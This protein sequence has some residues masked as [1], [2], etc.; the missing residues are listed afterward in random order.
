MRILL[1][2]DDLD[3]LH[4]A[5]LYLRDVARALRRRGHKPVVYG[6]RAGELATTLRD[7]DIPVVQSLRSLREIPDVVFGYNDVETMIAALRFPEVPVLS[8]S[9]GDATASAPNVVF[10]VTSSDSNRERLMA[11]QGVAPEKI[12]TRLLH[13][14]TERVEAREQAPG[15]IRRALVLGEHVR[16]LETIQVACLRLEIELDIL[17]PDEPCAER[18][19][20][21]YDLVFGL[22]HGALEAAAAGCALI[23]TDGIHLAAPLTVK[24]FDQLHRNAFG[25][26]TL[27]IPATKQ[28]LLGRMRELNLE[29][30][31]Q[32]AERIRTVAPL[33][34]ALEQLEADAE[35]ALRSMS[36]KPNLEET[37]AAAARYVE[38]F[39]SA[40]KLVGERS[41]AMEELAQVRSELEA[42]RA[43][44]RRTQD[45]FE[46]HANE[47]QSLLT[48]RTKELGRLR[49]QLRR[50][51]SRE[52]SIRHEADGLR[53]ELHTARGQ[54][55][56]TQE[57][58]RSTLQEVEALVG[59]KSWQVMEP[60]RQ[61]RRLFNRKHVPTGKVIDASAEPRDHTRE[62]SYEEWI[63]DNDTIT[64]TD[65]LL[66]RSH[67]AEFPVKPKL[68]IVMPVYDVDERFLRLALDSVLDQL[69]E[70]WELCIA[71]DASPAPH[72]RRVLREYEDRDPRVRVVY[73]RENGH[74]SAAS[75]SA[76][77]I[78]NGD[79]MV[80]MDHDD[81]LP[82]HALYMVAATLDEQPQLDLIFSDEDKIDEN[83]R[84]FAPYFKCEF[85]LDL[86]RSHNMV[87]HLGV[88]RMSIVKSIGGFRLGYEGSQDYDLALR[89]LDQTSLDRVKHIPFILYHW[90]AIQGS[91]AL[92]PGE[93]SYAHDAARRA[94]TD[95]LRRRGIDATSI[96]TP[97]NPSLH[98][99]RYHLTTEPRVSIVI[100]TKDRADLLSL[101]VDSIRART[102]YKNFEIVVA[103]NGSEEDDTHRLFCEIQKFDSIRVL[104]WNH[105]FNYSILNNWAVEQT[106]A[107]VI[108]FLNNDIEVETET[109]LTEMVAHAVQPDIGCVGARLYYPDGRLQHAGITLGVGGIA[110]HAYRFQ[111]TD[112]PGYF[113]RARVQQSVSAVT[114]ACL[115]IRRSVF[116]E[117]E[118]FDEQFRVAYGDVDLCLRASAAGY[119]TVYTPYAELTHHE[120]ATRGSD[121]VG[122]A[123]ERLQREADMMRARW[124]A[125]LDNDPAYSPNLTLKAD[126]FSMARET[127]VVKP[128]RPV[129]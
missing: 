5:G 87:S 90:R 101:C 18:Q 78:A 50:F 115:A 107:T 52:E 56:R 91:V 98:R 48:E 39:S 1:A 111:P 121:A 129:D 120:S 51:E 95:S 47:A 124:A 102:S 63:R 69:Y 42:D 80:L 19:L 68:S 53:N 23:I 73:R 4:D 77:E 6:T 58:H 3:T 89:F 122:S 75:N 62:Y 81:E 71:D 92:S 31:E 28:R 126:D 15:E 94:I 74:I 11:E 32:V 44:L 41:S 72:I 85:N 123:A 49:S 55:L 119:R 22:G 84:R 104:R 38:A 16:E 45:E 97:R 70:N 96:A 21:G 128:W 117:V 112:Y 83:G 76:I 27:E 2:I 66:I 86:F 118:G 46:H 34:L 12:L 26:S 33:K 114:A 17:A 60:I 65:R 37:C 82:K 103:D 14:D 127:R 93:K 64:E 54:L 40:F 106:D 100:P 20:A 24:T 7:A 113:W 57:A 59:S 88:Y 43:Q 29:S 35:R 36:P 10:Y 108:C 110:A 109:W 79:F 67:I 61:M 9:S 116:D 99:V 125:T 105:P 25:I 30:V 13:L 8:F